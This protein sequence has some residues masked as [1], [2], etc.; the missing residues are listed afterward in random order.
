MARELSV[1]PLGFETA[2]HLERARRRPR[3]GTVVPLVWVTVG[4]YIINECDAIKVFHKSLS[5]FPIFVVLVLI[6]YPR[7]LWKSW[8]IS[9]PLALYTAWAAASYLW[10]PDHHGVIS[11]S[12]EFL[13]AVVAGSLIGAALDKKTLCHV[14]AIATRIFITV[15]A[16]SLVVAHHWATKPAIDGAPGWHGPFGHKN[17]LGFEMAIGLIAL[18]YERPHPRGWKLWM[19]AAVVLLLGS[20]SGAGLAVALF[21]LA[22]AIQEAGSR[23][24]VDRAQRRAISIGSWLLAVVG[25]G[26]GITDFPAAAALLGKN[27]T[28]TGRTTIWR[29]VWHV[30]PGHLLLGW[31]YGGV[32]LGTTGET[33]VLWSRI[34]FP[35]Y[36]AH[37]AW[38]DLLLQVGLIGF[39]LMI[40]V[41]VRSLVKGWHGFRHGSPADRWAW[42]LLI[43]LVVEASVES[44]PI[45]GT[46]IFLVAVLA[47]VME[48]DAPGRRRRRAAG[49]RS[50]E[51]AGAIPRVREPRPMED[52]GAGP[53]R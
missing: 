12:I 51:P 11:H 22:V 20:E 24:A 45:A 35:V 34:G 49:G 28:L 31:G 39:V 47:T 6:A 14:F 42:L 48:R 26:I 44:A 30:I 33:A 16:V 29:A 15:S 40:V 21:V 7:R 32:W 37:D 43:A 52:R 38:L 53:L 36:E 17:G 2:A 10:T 3:S 25:I 5:T 46:G 19:L 23:R 9:V 13:S 18:Y 8:R 4:I 1:Q 27:S 41:L 50:G